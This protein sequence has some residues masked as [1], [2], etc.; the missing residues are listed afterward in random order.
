MRYTIFKAPYLFQKID[1]S[2][3]S[4]ALEIRRKIDITNSIKEQELDKSWQEFIEFLK[5]FNK[6]GKFVKCFFWEMEDRIYMIWVV[7]VL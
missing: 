7:N 4:E 1:R 3:I 2:I 6:K 5:K